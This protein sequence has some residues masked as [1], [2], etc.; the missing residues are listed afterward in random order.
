MRVSD[1]E[2]E[3]LWEMGADQDKI[4]QLIDEQQVEQP[5]EVLPENWPAVQLYLSVY[6]QFR[7]AA[8]GHVLGFD[9]NAVD[10]DIKRSGLELST[11]D[12]SKFK[13]LQQMTVTV[14]NQRSQS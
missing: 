13:M 6:G 2:A 10:I 12:W 9:L 4:D 11:Q 14:L 7:M 8:S 1:E 5:Y 3:E